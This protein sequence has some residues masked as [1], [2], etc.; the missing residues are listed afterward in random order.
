MKNY[1]WFYKDKNFV[2]KL[3]KEKLVKFYNSTFNYKLGWEPQPNSRKKES[4]GEHK[5]G[6]LRFDDL[7]RR[8]DPNLKLDDSNYAIFGDSFALSRQ[9]KD[10]STLAFYLGKMLDKYVPNYGVGNYGIDQAFLRYKKYKKK[11]INKHIIYIV[12]PETIV[13]INT[14]WRHLHETG[15]IFGFKPKFKLNKQNN[16]LLDKNPIY[17]FSDY[18]K[19]FNEF[20]N[21][22]SELTN[23]T[24]YKL[25][26]KE[27]AFNFSNLFGLKISIINKLFEYLEWL[28]KKSYLNKISDPDGLTIR[29]KSNSRFTNRC[30]SIF[31]TKELFTKLILEINSFHKGNMSI[32][33]LP[34]LSDFK[35][36][37]Q[38]TQKYFEQIRKKYNI[39]I[40]DAK[41]F[42][43]KELGSIKEIELIYVE[44]GFGGHLNKKGN[45]I[46]AKWIRSLI[47]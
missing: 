3:D 11:L 25:R 15:N 21:N 35:I 10:N 12:V 28:I 44:K 1:K 16:L 31:E 39:R 37:T 41:N 6:F 32:F 18:E 8:L 20:R 46:I 42:L 4:I 47:K 45:F 19:I 27:E 38:K 5:Y 7:S 13:R 2:S 29:M 22:N 30:Y 14:K 23:D 26:F 17:S 36:N 33:I 43:L 40:F 34:Q 9:V 24:M